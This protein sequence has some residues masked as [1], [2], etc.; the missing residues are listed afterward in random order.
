[1]VA[2]IGDQHFVVLGVHEHAGRIAQPG[3]AP[4]DDPDRRGI[5]VRLLIEEEQRVGR[6][7][8]GHHDLVALVIDEDR[9]DVVELRI[10][11]L[12]GA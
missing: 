11:A 4:L 10:R 8:V 5:P 1:M 9:L 3:V 6:A 2:P 7:A 12:D